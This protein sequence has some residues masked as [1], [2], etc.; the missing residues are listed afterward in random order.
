MQVVL[1]NK[2]AFEKVLADY[3]PEPKSIEILGNIP[4]V[5]LLGVT[6]S[7]RNTIIRH[8]VESGKYKQVVSDTTRPAKVRDGK[9]EEN[10]INYYFRS[11]EEILADLQD[12]K[13]L[14]AEIIHNQQVSGISVR[15]LEVA[16][17]S[18]KIPV[19]EVDLGGTDAILRAKPD[20]K[21]FFVIPPSYTEWMRRLSGREQMSEQELVNRLQTAI[22]VIKKGLKDDHFIFV[23]NDS[24]FDS[25]KRIDEQ[26]HNNK[27]ETH[28][29][30]AQLVAEEILKDIHAHHDI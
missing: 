10:G 29:A 24:S 9:L 19:N 28:H 21:F 12:G 20:T 5:I 8:L 14:E 1:R 26:V 11:E 23:I 18:G 6:A 16:Q 3:Q 13:F 15:E 2:Q 30:E 17:V 25:A 27:N 22:K 4:L 7:G